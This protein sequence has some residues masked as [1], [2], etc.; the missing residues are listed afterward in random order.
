M[1]SLEFLR[2]FFGKPAYKVR[3]K[4]TKIRSGSLHRRFQKLG[5]NHYFPK[6]TADWLIHR[7][8]IYGGIQRNVQKRKASPHDPRSESKI[9]SNRMRGG[10]RML[11]HGYAQ[12]YAR[13]LKLFDFENRL[14][15]AEFGILKGNGLA[16]WCDLFPNARILG[17]DIDTS[18]FEEN[19][20]N[21]LDRGG[22]S[23]NSPEIH[24]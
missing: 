20:Q 11:F 6:A 13:Y 4:L 12:E 2:N 8:L 5:P 14:V 9:M 1:S 18:H 3:K 10:D 24:T 21:L 16:I 15:I 7:E 19:R 17:F 23:S 22:F